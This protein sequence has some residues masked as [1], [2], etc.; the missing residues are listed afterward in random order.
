MTWKSGLFNQY[1]VHRDQ[2]YIALED[3]PDADFIWSER[4]IN[5]FDLLWNQDLPL[6]GIAAHFN[7]SETSVFIL[8]FDRALKGEIKAREGWKIW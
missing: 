4:E 7:T 6:K 2:I 1:R 5:Q 8:A 3:V